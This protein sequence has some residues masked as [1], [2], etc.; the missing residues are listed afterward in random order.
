MTSVIQ[1]AYDLVLR[2]RDSN[3]TARHY[4]FAYPAPGSTEANAFVHPLACGPI[5][6][7]LVVR[8]EIESVD[9][10]EETV[11]AGVRRSL[12]VRWGQHSAAIYGASTRP[13][14]NSGSLA[15][16]IAVIVSEAAIPGWY[17][18]VSVDGGATWRACNLR[19]K[20]LYTSPTGVNVELGLELEF[21]TKAPIVPSAGVVALGGVA[22]ADW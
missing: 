5:Q 9:F 16:T 8:E 11:Y 2:T 1:W 21:S 10:S 15:T 22:A 7:E 6:E 14:A 20:T 13:L 19:S 4:F 3:G 18:E 17:V 12:K